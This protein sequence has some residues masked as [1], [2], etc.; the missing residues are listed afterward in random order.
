MTAQDSITIKGSREGLLVTLPGELGAWPDAL[1]QLE[2]K[3]S[4]NPAFFKG[5]RVGLVVGP[6][7]LDEDNIRA[8]REMLVRHDVILWALISDAG[9]TQNEAAHLG[10]DNKLPVREPR[11]KAVEQAVEPPAP[12]GPPQT[13]AQPSAAPAEDPD[14]AMMVRRTLRSGVRVHHPG[15]IIVLGDVHPGAEVVAGGDVVVWGK[16]HGTAHAGALGDHGAVVCALDFAP[17]QLRIGH[18]ITRSPDDRRR[19]A[20]PE[21]GRVRNGRIEVVPWNP[22]GSD[23]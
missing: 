14:A 19:K 4:A 20:Q 11:R 16:L 2:A 17:T 15:S 10:L 5:A 13:A 12:P 18:F 22:K 6:R 7:V 23:R 21:T 8:A 9:F 3:L 1:A